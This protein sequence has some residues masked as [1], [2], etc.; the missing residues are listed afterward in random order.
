MA[1]LIPMGHAD[2]TVIWYHGIAVLLHVVD[3]MKAPG[4]SGGFFASATR[5]QS[6]YYATMIATYKERIGTMRRFITVLGLVLACIDLALA[7]SDLMRAVR[8]ERSQ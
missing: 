3:V 4:S 6:G 1:G 5:H 2:W 8:E 7:V